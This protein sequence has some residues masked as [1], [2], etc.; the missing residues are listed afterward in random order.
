M[1]RDEVRGHAVNV[2]GGLADDLDVPDNPI[3]N[4]RVLAECFNASDNST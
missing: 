3:L 2:A 1:P 4:Q